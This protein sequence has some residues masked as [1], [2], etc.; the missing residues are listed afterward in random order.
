MQVPW[1]PFWLLSVI[2]QCQQFQRS[3]LKPIH[4][5]GRKLLKYHWKGKTC[6]KWAHEQNIDDSEK[7]FP[8]GVNQ[9]VCD[10]N[11]FI[12]IYVYQISVENLHDHWSSSLT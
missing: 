5:N 12:G 11:M 9:H 7:E 4:L 10:Q 1:I 8:P 6:R 3:S 2:I